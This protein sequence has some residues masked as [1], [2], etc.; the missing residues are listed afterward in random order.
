MSPLATLYSLFS[1]KSVLLNSS[2]VTKLYSLPCCS[3]GLLGRVV[4]DR[5]VFT[6]PLLDNSFKVVSFDVAIEPDII[7]SLL[8]FDSITYLLLTYIVIIHLYLFVNIYFTLY[9][10]QY[11][12]K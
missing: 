2:S 12:V 10:N 5:R 1:M 4:V 6:T 7:N 3:E 9:K 8:L 11:Q